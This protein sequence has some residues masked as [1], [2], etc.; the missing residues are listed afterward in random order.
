MFT[1]LV[2]YCGNFQ[3]QDSRIGAITYPLYMYHLV[4]LILATS[5]TDAEYSYG[6]FVIGMIGSIVLAVVMA[7]VIDPLIDRYR[8]RIRG[9]QLRS[10]Q[11]AAARLV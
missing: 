4:V 9:L 2:R 10:A 1:L 3:R 8:D 7:S 6:S 11:P 5:Y